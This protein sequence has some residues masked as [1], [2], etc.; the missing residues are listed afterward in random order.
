MQRVVT[1][2]YEEREKHRSKAIIVFIYVYIDKFIY[3]E[4]SGDILRIPRGDWTKSPAWSSVLK[5]VA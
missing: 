4:N 2:R 3:I 1:L 5:Y